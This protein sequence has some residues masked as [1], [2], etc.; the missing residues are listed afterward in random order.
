MPS[1]ALPLCLFTTLATEASTA[2]PTSNPMSSHKFSRLPTPTMASAMETTSCRPSW[3]SSQSSASTSS[4]CI[5]CFHPQVPVP[6]PDGPIP[7]LAERRHCL[8]DEDGRVVD[9]L[10][11]DGQAKHRHGRGPAALHL[12]PRQCCKCVS[13]QHRQYDDD[14]PGTSAKVI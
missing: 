7:P 4:Y 12:G 10:R 14:G 8:L 2:K 6:H 1:R 5:P 11:K 9:E 13:P 3:S